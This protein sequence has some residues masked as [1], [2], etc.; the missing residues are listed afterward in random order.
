M[1]N[2]S[3]FIWLRNTRQLWKLA[4][5]VWVG[6]L[7][8]GTVGF[9]LLSLL[10]VGFTG[11]GVFWV[12]GGAWVLWILLK[13]G[14]LM[15]TYYCIRCAQCGHNPTRRADGNWLGEAMM[16]HRLARL[17]SCPRCGDRGQL[18]P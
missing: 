12:V 16:Y 11:P 13:L 18:P 5:E 4:A 2:P 7:G 3:A 1:F 8:A 17:E 9:G 15:L 14:Q 10:L 6:L